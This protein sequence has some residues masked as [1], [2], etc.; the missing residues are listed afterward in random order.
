MCPAKCP[1]RGCVHAA[2]APPL[3]V[4]GPRVPDSQRHMWG[5]RASVG[6][7]TGRKHRTEART[8]APPPARPPARPPTHG[9]TGGGTAPV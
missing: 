8:H 7:K 5:P 9:R 3:T 1:P 6:P 4:P 2:Q